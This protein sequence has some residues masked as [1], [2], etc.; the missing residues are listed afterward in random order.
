ML[1]SQSL[2]SLMVSTVE[3]KW[4]PSDS[5]VT[6]IIESIWP[7][8]SHLIYDCG[9]VKPHGHTQLQF[10][11]KALDPMCP[12]PSPKSA[13]S[14]PHFMSSVCFTH[15]LGFFTF[16][17]SSR[18]TQSILHP[19]LATFK[20]LSYSSLSTNHLTSIILRHI[21]LAW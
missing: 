21:G 20:F 8:K 13:F 15:F 19:G 7:L 1:Q 9:T 3:E 11:Q 5:F 14:L 10:N 2:I 16:I 17:I 12:P 4:Q 18:F 6:L